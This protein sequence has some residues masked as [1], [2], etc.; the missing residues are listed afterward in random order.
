[1]LGIAVSSMSA[2]TILLGCMDITTINKLDW[3]YGLFLVWVILLVMVQA[4]LN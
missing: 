4:R 3:R 1:M 2:L